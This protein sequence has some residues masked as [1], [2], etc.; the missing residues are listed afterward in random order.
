M[1]WAMLDGSEAK[2]FIDY[3][4]IAIVGGGSLCAALLSFPLG[5]VLKFPSVLKQVLFTKSR[6]PRELIKELVHFA[7]VAR[8]DGILS[9]ENSTRD[10]KDEFLV[11][12]IQMAVDGTDPTLIENIMESELDAIESRH[13]AGKS[14]LDNLGKYA[15]AFGMIGTLI[16]LVKMLANM[17]DPNAIGPG[18]A[19]ALLT[20]LYGSYV[21]NMVALPLSEKLSKRN[22]EEILIKSIIL[23]GVMAIQSGDNPRVVEQK[24]KTYLPVRLREMTQREAA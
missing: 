13:G 10:I 11:S 12:G 4:S 22:D 24:L 19:C 18:M 8:R 2:L 21:S 15:P 5:E 6:D 7:E 14:L 16:G 1:I 17:D 20:T 9:L 3:P 23:R